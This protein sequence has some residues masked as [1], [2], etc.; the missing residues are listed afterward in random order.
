[1]TKPHAQAKSGSAR[2]AQSA[3]QKD[4]LPLEQMMAHEEASVLSQ[5]PA[6]KDDLNRAKASVSKLFYLNYQD[7]NGNVSSVPLS[8]LIED[9]FSGGTPPTNVPEYWNG[10]IQW[11]TTKDITSNLLTTTSDFISELGLKNSSSKLAKA[12]SILVGMHIGVG[13]IALATK[14]TA[15]NQDLR[16]LVPNLT[17]VDQWYLLYFLH[18]SSGKLQAYGRGSTVK[19]ITQETL[20]QMLVPVP[21]LAVQQRIGALFKELDRNLSLNRAQLEKLTQLKTSMLEQ[22][23]PQEDEDVPRLRFNGFTEP[24][25]KITLNEA[26][27]NISDGVHNLPPEAKEGEGIPILSAKDIDDFGNLLFNDVARHASYQSFQSEFKRN[28]GIS[29]G[30][31]LITIVGS[32]GRVAIVNT[33]RCFMLQRS[34]AIIKPQYSKIRSDFLHTTITHPSSQIWLN[35]TAAGSTQ[36]G[37]YLNKLSSMVIMAPNLAEQE[38][39][40]AFFQAL[41]ERLALQRAKIEKLEQLKKALLEQMFV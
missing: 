39:I 21:S 2:P 25:Q 22:M 36:K 19:G 12:G 35:E 38:R 32:I 26:S 37:I 3:N 15:I 27:S 8:E 34:V 4:M 5:A 16:A 13:K 6:A 30:D 41:D 23:F 28:E 40:G 11:A 1:M 17:K 31:V 18:A 10:D 14:D 33:T 24:W 7:E 9:S 29:F 20:L